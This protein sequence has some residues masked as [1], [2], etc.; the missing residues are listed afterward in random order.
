MG[1]II[2]KIDGVYL[3]EVKFHESDFGE[4]T[5]DNVEIEV[6]N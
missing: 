1:S 3:D 5:E 6:K 2:I 4:I